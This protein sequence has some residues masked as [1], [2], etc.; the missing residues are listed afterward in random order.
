MSDHTQDGFTRPVGHRVLAPV[1]GVHTLRTDRLPL[2]SDPTALTTVWASAGAGKTTLLAQWRNQLHDE[3]VLC[4]WVGLA[5]PGEGT[6]SLGEAVQAAFTAERRSQ[7]TQHGPRDLAGLLRSGQ[8]A[9]LFLDDLHNLTGTVDGEWLRGLL[10][11][12]PPSLRV[13]MAGR[14]TPPRMSATPLDTP[15]TEYRSDDL[16]FTR[17]ETV[18]FLEARGI[19]LDDDSLDALLEHTSG[20][21]VSLVLLAERLSHSDQPTQLPAGFLAD[22]RSVGDYLV[23]EVLAGVS[24][25]ESHFL[26]TTSVVD[27][28]TVPLA[29]HLT[30]REDAG[31]IIER[32]VARMALVGREDLGGETVYRYHVLLRGFLRAESRRRNFTAFLESIARA[33]DWYHTRG[34]TRDA[35]ELALRAEDP[36]RVAHLVAEHG[37]QL[38]FRGLAPQV[39]DALDFLERSG[40]SSPAIH[41]V[42]AMVMLP[43]SSD[44]SLIGFHLAAAE[45]DAA[46]LRPP[47]R[48]LHTAMQ[49]LD[50]RSADDAEAALALLEA[51]DGELRSSPDEDAAAEFLDAHLVVEWARARAAESAGNPDSAYRLLLQLASSTESDR[52]AWLHLL[53]LQ[54]AATLA[55]RRG[56]WAEMVALEDRMLLS[57]IP[58]GR[59]TDLAAARLSLAGSAQAFRE[60]MDGST[61]SLDDV[62]SSRPAKFDKE[63]ALEAAAIRLMIHLDHGSGT[64]EAFVN[65]E[66][67]MLTHGRALP[68]LAAACAYRFVTFTLAFRNREQA[69]EAVA[70]VRSVLG[71]SAAES[72]LVTALYNDAIG[73][74]AQAEQSLRAALESRAPASDADTAV[75]IPLT[76]AFWAERAGRS[77]MADQW[78]TRSLEQAM[79]VRAHRPFVVRRGFGATLVASRLGR[80]GPLN[81]FAADLVR[82]Y[83][84]LA[85]RQEAVAVEVP[86]TPKE[87]EV[88]RELP[89]HQSVGDIAHRLQLSP[90][91]VKTHI[92][93]LYQKLGVNTRTEA[94]EHASNAGLL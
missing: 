42:T 90:N 14:Y 32:L 23:S 82:E 53:V 17:A 78:L 40:R 56:W 83:E 9:A 20:W 31:E 33:S 10:E 54:E 64:R 72:V 22:Q 93:S 19:V 7:P 41:V 79:V 58:A 60:S 47:L 43:F 94:V 57:P 52:A 45:P 26:L 65:L 88:L 76:L 36:D 16:A 44:R 80:L 51:R 71:S 34:E 75:L 85:E 8:P 63:L 24:R 1:L 87:R 39:Q 4:L 84:A 68:R 28:F 18:E 91:T 59:P 13:V 92:R 62:L 66:R 6:L 89:L 77:T 61:A 70:L 12:R 81:P 35:L 2:A 69:R 46:S 74:Q 37:V 50:R 29:V 67:L 30:G 27:W 21:A 38:I 55:A 86:I 49:V 25:T 3:G 48:L 5:T 11:T 73:R 15:I